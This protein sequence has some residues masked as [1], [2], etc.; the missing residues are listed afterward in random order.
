MTTDPA[1]RPHLVL[2]LL[3]LAASL[4][5]N[6]GQASCVQNERNPVKKRRSDK[7]VFPGW[8]LGMPARCALRSVAGREVGHL[9]LL[10]HLLPVGAG[11]A[12]AQTH[13][14][15][16]LA[17]HG[18]SHVQRLAHGGAAAGWQHRAGGGVQLELHELG[19][20]SLRGQGG[21]QRDSV[22]SAEAHMLLVCACMSSPTPH[23]QSCM[24]QQHPVPKPGTY[25]P[26]AR[27]SAQA[28]QWSWSK[29]R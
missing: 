2:L 20:C 24:H 15:R 14:Q 3:S 19:H 7:A 21:G 25:A 26:G 10:Q 18:V 28:Q 23:A 9:A 27:S 6:R 17:V 22:V 12:D 1:C 4:T 29:W 16:L 5:K 11:V 8:R 13:D